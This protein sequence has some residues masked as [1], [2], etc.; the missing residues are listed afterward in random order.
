MKRIARAGS[1]LVLFIV[2]TALAIAQT[3]QPPEITFIDFPGTIVADGK[4]VTGLVVFKDSDG[5]ITRAEL[6]VVEAQDFQ[7]FTLD[8]TEQLKGKV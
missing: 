1:S 8:L 5:D 4:P 2:L 3:G 6:K 7:S